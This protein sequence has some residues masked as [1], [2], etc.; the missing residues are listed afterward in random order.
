GDAAFKLAGDTHFEGIISKR[1]DQPYHGGRSDGWRKTKLLASDEFA[2][3]GYTAP[4]GSRTG[5]GSLLLAKPD[6]VHGWLYAGRVGSGFNDALM[7][8]VTKMLRKGGGKTPT[9]HVP[10]M[11]TDLRGATWF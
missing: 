4:K 1:M 3:V 2:V 8:E 9:V 7:A 11:D 6:P 5:F 10:T